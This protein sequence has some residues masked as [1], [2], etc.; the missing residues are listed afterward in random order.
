MTSEAVTN[1]GP[2]L[3]LSKLNRLSLLAGL[4]ARVIVPVPVYDEVVGAGRR[5]GH[6]DARTTELFLKQV[7]W[8]PEPCPD[9][10]VELRDAPLDRGERAAIAIALKRGSPLL[11]DEEAG[12]TVARRY[13]VPVCGSLGVL[14]QAYRRGLVT[15][16]DLRLDFGEMC[17]RSDIWIS[18]SLCNRVLERTLSVGLGSA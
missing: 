3:V 17:T 10:P 12:R 14:V 13:G 4:Y 7:G 16:A 18:P 15:E 1:A 8:A 5:R 2:L 11:M 6:E 9:I